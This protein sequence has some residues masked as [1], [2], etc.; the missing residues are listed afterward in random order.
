MDSSQVHGLLVSSRVFG[1]WWPCT[2]GKAFV[3]IPPSASSVD[4]GQGPT[5]RGAYDP[6]ADTLT[7]R[8]SDH[9][10]SESDEARPEAILDFDGTGN[11]ARIG[12]LKTSEADAMP[13]FIEYAY[14]V[15]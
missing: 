14:G 11:V 6:E 7:V 3:P 8:F 12:M 9:L 10:V 2:N 13:R 15:S 4:A 1:C 5:P